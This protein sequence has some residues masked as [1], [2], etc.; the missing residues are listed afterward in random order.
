MSKT[1]ELIKQLQD[2]VRDLFA[3]DRYKD[4]LKFLS[5]FHSYSAGNCLL[6]WSQ[7]PEATMCASYSDWTQKHKRQV[8]RGSQ[9][10]KI[11]APHTIKETDENG[12][13]HTSIGFHAASCF[14]VSQTYSLDGESLPDIVRSLDM[15]VDYYMDLVSVLLSISP[16]PIEFEDIKGSAR[17]YFSPSD[18]R[19]AIQQG[20]SEA[21]TIKTVLHE[22]SHAWLHAK[23]AEEESADQRTREVEAESVAYVVSQWL[24]I[25][26]SDYSLGYVAGWSSDK[27]T[28]ELRASLE[29]I[30]K[31]SDMMIGLIE[32]AM[33]NELHQRAAC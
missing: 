11:L 5:S 23:G 28:P 12:I 14:D 13:D 25:D 33:N 21:D 8:K 17:G 22:Q 32:E 26:S 29:I 9:A 27:S 19:I 6:I 3:S 24:G 20:M 15:D 10:I 18:C 30:R 4:Y 31:T 1:Q 16:V 2:G 7:M